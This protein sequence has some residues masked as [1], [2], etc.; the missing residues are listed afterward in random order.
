MKL[1]AN[2]NAP[3]S[4]FVQCITTVPHSSSQ[5][6]FS[7]R[8]IAPKGLTSLCN[9]L[10]FATSICKKVCLCECEYVLKAQKHCA[11]VC[12][13]HLGSTLHSITTF[14]VMYCWRADVERL[15]LHIALLQASPLQCKV[16]TTCQC[17]KDRPP[18]YDWSGLYQTPL[19]DERHLGKGC[20]VL[21]WN[22]NSPW[23]EIIRCK[24]NLSSNCHLQLMQTGS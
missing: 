19:K 10:L 13:A 11:A 12:W 3:G 2:I 17:H 5:L 15:V 16:N 21:L 8:T 1:M 7:C 9:G 14:P 4:V 6:T 20:C 22:Y 18:D 23:R 24:K